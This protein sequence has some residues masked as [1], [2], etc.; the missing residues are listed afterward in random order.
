MLS[1]QE[2]IGNPNFA[3]IVLGRMHNFMLTNSTFATI[4]RL[5]K[6]IQLFSVVL[7]IA[8]PVLPRSAPAIIIQMIWLVVKRGNR[9][10]AR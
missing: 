7:R 5:S 2:W 9:A 1:F 10:T 8:L 6:A 3:A 4:T